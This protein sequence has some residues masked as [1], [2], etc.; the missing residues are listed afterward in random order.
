MLK[1]IRWR[2]G[3]P[4][5][6]L[7]LVLMAVLGLYLSIFIHRT[8]IDTLDTHLLSEARLIGRT[9][10]VL[11]Q[12]REIDDYDELAEQWAETLGSRVTIIA[13][14]G[15]VLGDSDIE[16]TKLDNH[17]NRPEVTEALATGSGLITRY[18]ATL[19]VNLRYG[20]I[21]FASPDGSRMVLR[22]AMPMRQIEENITQ[23]QVTMLGTTILAALTAILLADIIARKTSRPLRE[24]TQSATKLSRGDFSEKGSVYHPAPNQA[25]EIELLSAAFNTMADR[26]HQQFKAL[27][28]ERK[29]TSAVLQ[30]MTDGVVIIN[31]DGTIQLINPAV[32]KMLDIEI[33][34]PLGRSMIEVLRFHQ[35]VEA[36]TQVRQSGGT[37][38]ETLELPVK[39]MTLQYIFTPLDQ[40]LPG[41]TLLL[42]QNVTH[43][44]R[45]ETVRRDF[46]SNVSHELRTPLASLKALTETLQE[47]ALDDHQAARR[48]LIQMEVEV[49]ALSQMVNELLELSRIE[50][51][52]VPLKKKL[53]A[54]AEIINQGVSRM[55]LQAERAQIHVD[56][57]C[58]ETLPLILADPPRLEQVVINLFH[59]AIKYTSS[60]G[61]INISARPDGKS[62]LFIFQ[63]TGMGIPQ[64][65][66]PRIF[67]RFYKADRARTS[68][69][70]GLGLAIAKHLVEAHGGRIWVESVETMGSTF[71]F[72]IPQ[73]DNGIPMS[74]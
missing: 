15:W 27:E 9:L 35:F 13:E 69:G 59:N 44:R 55:R 17:L 66:L 5:V 71:F 57:D 20:A 25:D 61:K 42:I 18:S 4:F 40:I 6:A 68:G 63:D 54:P 2:F 33:G 49:D 23:L 41:C 24:L 56:V 34:E 36:W 74:R 60:G 58:P 8:Y 19:K 12:N 38:A 67:E 53:I 21:A 10:F 22:I 37:V 43:Q 32:M 65:D 31:Q 30:E 28:D 29:Q 45:L 50:S 51:G 72:S 14:D 16:H 62:V 73:A 7:I 3:L 46:I 48:F 11:R 39:K 47:S 26:I 1:S 64:A 70:T 52:Q